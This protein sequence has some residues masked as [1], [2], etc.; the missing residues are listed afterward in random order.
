MSFNSRQYEWADLTLVLGGRDVTG[1]RGIKYTTKS[2][3]EPLFAKGRHA[4]SIQTGNETIEGEI[5]V[6]QSELIAL[7]QAGGGSITGLNLDAVVQYGNPSAGD[8]PTTDRIV[9]LKFS[10]STKEFKQGDK[11]MECNIPFMALRVKN[12]V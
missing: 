5:T 12:Q 11:F 2:E 7:E 4:H 3:L 1:I 6:L 9:G 8:T 10:E